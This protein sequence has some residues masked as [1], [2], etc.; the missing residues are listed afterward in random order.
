[1]RVL[2]LGGILFS[3]PFLLYWDRNGSRVGVGV[4]VA[5]GV[6]VGVGVEVNF[7][8]WTESNK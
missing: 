7:D 3:L 4:G 5:A 1:M 6:G 8:M 2:Y